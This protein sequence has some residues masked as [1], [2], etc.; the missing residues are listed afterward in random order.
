MIGSERRERANALV[1]PSPECP[2]TIYQGKASTGFPLRFNPDFLMREIE[3]FHFSLRESALVV[4][5]VCELLTL[6]I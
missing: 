4:D 2:I 3:F 6:V 1:F 5:V